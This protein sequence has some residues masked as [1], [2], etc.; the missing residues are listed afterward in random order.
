[1]PRD[2]LREPRSRGTDVAAAFFRT[3]LELLP[4]KK[5]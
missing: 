3:P 1:M 5:P 4:G 2:L